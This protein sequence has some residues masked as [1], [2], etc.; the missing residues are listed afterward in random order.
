MDRRM[1]RMM[2]GRMTKMMKKRNRKTERKK[3]RE[4]HGKMRSAEENRNSKQ[5]AGCA[6]RLAD[7]L[8]KKAAANSTSRSRR[9]FM[10]S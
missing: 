2:E 1:E 9:L 7:P 6:R 3:K 4:N 5:K 8:F 10:V